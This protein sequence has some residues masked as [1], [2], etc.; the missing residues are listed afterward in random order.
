MYL[1]LDL[2]MYKVSFMWCWLPSNCLTSVIYQDL[3]PIQVYMKL[4]HFPVM[5]MRKMLEFKKFC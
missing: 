3:S 4:F 1:K 5:S 2:S